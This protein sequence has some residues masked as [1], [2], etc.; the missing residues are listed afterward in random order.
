MK[1][2]EFFLD[3]L[4]VAPGTD[5]CLFNRI[6]QIGL[7]RMLKY[8]LEHLTRLLRERLTFMRIIEKGLKSFSLLEEK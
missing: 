4:I 8:S 7:M 3:L 1:K 6:F 5:I 2:R